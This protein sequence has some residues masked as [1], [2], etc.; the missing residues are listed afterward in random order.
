MKKSATG[1]IRVDIGTV[2]PALLCE[3]C[4]FDCHNAP[5]GSNAFYKLV[6]RKTAH[7]FI[8]PENGSSSSTVDLMTAVSS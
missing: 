4:D 5:G 1:N 8:A 3:K 2:A 7:I 6:S